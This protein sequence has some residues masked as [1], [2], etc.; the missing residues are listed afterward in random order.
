M[1]VKRIVIKRPDGI[2]QFIG[3]TS[4]EQPPDMLTFGDTHYSLV[5]L[6]KHGGHYLY[7]PLMS[8]SEVMAAYRGDGTHTSNGPRTF[9]PGQK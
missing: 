2:E 3:L 1:T 6:G 5:K 9:K 4:G 8:P 7:R